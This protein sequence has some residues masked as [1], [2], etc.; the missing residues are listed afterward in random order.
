ME[1]CLRLKFPHLK[2]MFSFMLTL[3]VLL[4]TP[5][6]CQEKTTILHSYASD[7][8]TLSRADTLQIFT[9]N[10]QYWPDGSK[11]TVYMLNSDAPLHQ[12]FSREHLRMFPYQLDRLWNQITYSGQ[13]E[14]P[15]RVKNEMELINAVMNTPGAIGYATETGI[16]QYSE[17][18]A[19]LQ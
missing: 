16:T 15:R 6:L 19:Q 12:R 1:D 9:G 8:L 14:P 3:S 5:A 11:I 10:R 4:S 7:G 2:I 13:G 18:K 17:R